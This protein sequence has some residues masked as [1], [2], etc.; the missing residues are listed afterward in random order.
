MPRRANLRPS[1]KP[2]GTVVL[3][4][5]K[6]IEYNT[7]TQEVSLIALAANRKQRD[8][9]ILYRKHND[10]WICKSTKRPLDF[11]T[12]FPELKS[13]K[14][15]SSV[16]EQEPVFANTVMPPKPNV[17]N[18]ET[19]ELVM[20]DHMATMNFIH[21][22]YS[23]KPDELFISEI[24][25]KY[26]VRNVLRGKNILME[27]PSGCGKTMTAVAVSKAFKE[28]HPF[29]YFNLGATQDPRATLI[30]NTHFSKDS[31]TYF[32]ESL[33]VKSIQ[34]KNAIIMLDELSRAHP[35]AWNILMT[36]LDPNQKYLRLDEKEGT[37]TIKVAAGV[38]FMATANVGTEFTSTRIMD[39]ALLDRFTRV[40]MEA[41]TE[42]EEFMLLQQR[43]PKLSKKLLKAIAEIA[44]MTRQEV[45][46][47]NS[48]ISTIISTR[49]SEEIASLLYDGFNL[50]DA[51][52]VLIYPLYSDAGGED[53]ERTFVKQIVQ[54]FVEENNSN[55]ELFNTTM[56]NSSF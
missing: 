29:F 38:C 39:R 1:I 4:D 41:L 43:F 7:P 31:G 17:V 40:E 48:K 53:S 22:S 56:I 34:T 37:P 8:V 32:D 23:M 28:E 52:E 54:K 45:K 42:Q 25:W 15:Q 9:F 13:Y 55:D 21:T 35:E 14:V 26:L 2:S 5:S 47:N 44:D 46:Q 27:G 24:K 33:F 19:G 50:A 10:T 36:V 51:A 30:G 3:I 6:G 16:V 12:G 49:A 20:D 18:Q 11:V